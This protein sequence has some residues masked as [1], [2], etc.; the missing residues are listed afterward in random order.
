MFTGSLLWNTV[1][2]S[3]VVIDGILFVV[4][5]SLKSRHFQRMPGPAFGFLGQNTG[6]AQKDVEQPLDDL[7]REEG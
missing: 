4:P 2:L 6:T 5:G 1:D 3:P 7:F